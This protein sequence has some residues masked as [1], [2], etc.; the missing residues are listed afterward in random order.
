MKLTTGFEA[1]LRATMPKALANNTHSLSLSRTHTH[2]HTHTSRFMPDTFFCQAYLCW[3]HSH[4]HTHTLKLAL[5]LTLTYNKSN[6]LGMQIII[7]LLLNC[8]LLNFKENLVKK[9]TRFLN[10]LSNF[11]EVQSSNIRNFS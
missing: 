10:C 8:S 4:L 9:I 1:F 7:C 6:L 2:T 11:I 5:N 3:F